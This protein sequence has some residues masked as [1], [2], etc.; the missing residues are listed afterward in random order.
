MKNLT[1][2]R[3]IGAFAIFLIGL[4]A[5]GTRAS[6]AGS[7]ITIKGNNF[8][9]AIGDTTPD[10]NDDTDFDSITAIDGVGMVKRTF[11]IFNTGTSPLTLTGTPKVSITG[12]TNFT[13]TAEPSGTIAPNSSTTFQIAFASTVGGTF[14]ASVAIPNDDADESNYTFAISGVAVSGSLSPLPAQTSTFS[15]NVRGY[16]F[17]SPIDV[18]ITGLRV[19]T[20]ASSGNQSIAILRLDS[21]PPNFSATTNSFTTL[22]LTQNNPE[23]GILPVSIPISAGD[24]IGVMGNRGGVNSY[25]SSAGSTILGVPVEFRRLGM[26]FPLATTAPRDLWTE[27]GQTSSISRVEIYAGFGNPGEIEVSGNGAVIHNNDST[28][29][30]GDHTDFGSAPP[31]G[32]TV[33]RTFTVAN[34]SSGSLLLTKTPARVELSGSA[35]FTL[36]QDATTP[37]PANGTSTFKVTFTPVANGPQTA[38]VMIQNGDRNETNYTFSISGVGGEAPAPTVT[39]ISPAT[40][41]TLGGTPVTITGTGF[42]GATGVTIGGTAATGVSVTNDTTL[43]ATTPA[44]TAGTA[45]VVVTTPGGANA[46]NTLYTYAAPAPAATHWKGQTNATWSGTNW[47][48]D[49]AGTATTAIPTSTSDI[50]FSATGAQNLTTTLDQDFTI[51]SLTVNSTA[52]I[53]GINALTITGATNVANGT[54]TL[55]NGVT[56]TSQSNSRVEATGAGATSIVTGANSKWNTT[57]ALS[58]GFNASRTGT[59]NVLNGGSV[60]SSSLSAGANSGAT[61]TVTVSGAG[62]MLTSSTTSIGSS[63]NGTLNIESGGVQTTNGS[64]SI[65]EYDGSVGVATVTGA[66]SKWTIREN[67]II[68]SG[69]DGTLKILNGG[70]VSNVSAYLATSSSLKAT[71]IVNGSGSKWENSGT[72]IIGQVGPATLDIQNGGLVSSGSSIIGQFNGSTGKVTVTGSGSKWTSNSFVSVSSVGPGTLDIKAGGVVTSV[73]GY[74]G[75]TSVSDGNVTVDGSGSTWDATSGEIQVGRNGKGA[76]QITNGGQVKNNE[77]L[78]VGTENG[79]NG[80]VSVATFGQLKTSG[81]VIGNDV[82]AIGRVSVDG[83]G[84]LWDAGARE[85]RLG[86]LGTGVLTLS[87]GAQVTTTATVVVAG[88]SGSKGTLNIGAFVDGSNVTAATTG[89]TFTASEISAGVGNATLNFNQSNDTTFAPKLTGSVKVNQL[90]SGTTTLTGDSTYQGVTTVSAG[91]LYVNGNNPTAYGDITVTGGTLGGSG[92]IGGPVAVQSGGTITAGSNATSTGLLVVGGFSLN[93]GSTALFQ[94]AG[95]SSFDQIRSPGIIA[96]SG[97]HTLNLQLTGDYT[98]NAGDTFKIFDAN[99]YTLDAATFNVTSN[100]GSQFKWDLSDLKSKGEVKIAFVIPPPT[101]TGISPN[102]G[103][104]LGGTTVTITGTDFTGVTAVTI[105]GTAAT[106]VNVVNATTLTCTTPAGAAG[107]ASVVVTTPSGSNAAN[108]LFTYEVLADLAVTLTSSPNPVLA[109]GNLTFTLSLT[110][111]GPSAAV[112]PT[113]SLPLPAALTFVSANA[114][115]GWQISNPAVGAGGTVTISHSTLA[116]GATATFTVIS[117]VIAAT[118]N[119]TQ[120][121]AVATCGSSSRDLTSTNNSSSSPTAAGTVNPTS[122]QLTAIGVINRQNGMFDFTVNVTNTTPYPINGF[123]LRIDFSSYL[124]AHPSL[125]LYNASSAPGSAD[126]FVNYPY[127]VPVDGVIPVKLSF[128]TVNRAFPNPFA[129]VLTVEA[130]PTSA[131]S[132]TDGSGVQPRMV[133]LSD[134][135]VLLEF[136]STPG[137]WYRIRYSSDMVNW[138]ECPVPIQ[139]ANNRMQWIDSGAPFTNAPPSSVPSRFYRVNEIATPTP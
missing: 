80:I 103:G 102:T 29:S 67:L 68:D 5:S 61:G 83:S 41:S 25:T 101:V 110:N 98:G 136:P 17:V 108:T 82:S 40:G 58:V 134:N 105:G 139:A 75:L 62:S 43:T 118:P 23:S 127:P 96:Y 8:E 52:G 2:S 95:T 13:V 60:T 24:I 93:S 131:V 11:T 46:A 128:Y 97:T 48:S 14:T 135:N 56:V 34:P 22:F 89:G 35:T 72:I 78:I 4:A 32:G 66:G 54:L 81:A 73:S 77:Q 86:K 44:G 3:I 137:R 53:G 1:L 113:V 31:G 138:F 10:A 111:N 133:G 36:T 125:R 49:S 64:A 63:G 94:L 109:S 57:G 33:E 69:G 124:V 116:N 55:S 19:P 120:W 47:A 84:S 99:S 18:L 126:V 21:T 92:V 65:G 71:A 100:L 45:S 107:T 37:I 70:V 15:G 79:A 39:G 115:D 88:E 91:A 38:T 42:T 51:Q 123:R 130:L 104:T 85:I 16:Y 106:N 28:P 119:G 27:P 121:N 90:G 76:L 7:E 50:T 114:P 122:F 26:Q 6:A 12:A 20:D 112:N 87:N 74:V 117:K 9:I 129:P 132:N 30:L 59:L